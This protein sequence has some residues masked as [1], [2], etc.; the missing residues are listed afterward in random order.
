MAT[1][2][3]IS[4]VPASGKTTGVR[5]LPSANTILIDADK[6]GMSWAGWKKDF[7]KE[8]KNYFATSDMVD[9]TKILTF[10]NSKPEVKYIVI[11]TINSIMSDKEV[12]DTKRPGFDESICR[13]KI[14]LIAGISLRSMSYNIMMKY[15]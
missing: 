15:A 14:S 2:V 7:N 11:D 9:I 4:G 12:A 5:F 1:L 13:S 3:Q 6:K 8:N 10:A